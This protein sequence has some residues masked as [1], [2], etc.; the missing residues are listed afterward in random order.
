MFLEKQMQKVEG[1]VSGFEEHLA[2]DGAVLDQ[3]NALLI[4]NQQLQV[5][6]F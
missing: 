4:R 5:S 3:P 1:V 6:Y 2:K